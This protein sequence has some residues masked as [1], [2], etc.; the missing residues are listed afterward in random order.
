[1]NWTLKD[2]EQ[3]LKDKKITG[4]KITGNKEDLQARKKPK[5]KIVQKKLLEMK[6]TLDAAAVAY[7]TEYYFAKPRMFRFDIAIP[8]RKIAIEYEGI[9]SAKSRHTSVKGY[10]RDADKYNLAT[11]LG[12]KVL[13]YTALNVNK[14][15]SDLKAILNG[16]LRQDQ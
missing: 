1:M 16:K 14:F 15:E 12:W 13:R 8:D 11:Q 6:L 9:M 3:L 7:K 10:T 5:G 4:M 2:I